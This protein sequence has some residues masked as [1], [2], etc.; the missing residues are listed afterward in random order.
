[1][2]AYGNVQCILRA[3]REI[4]SRVV[5]RLFAEKERMERREVCE[6]CEA[7]GFQ[8]MSKRNS[9][10]QCARDDEG[11]GREAE[12][13]EHVPLPCNFPQVSAPVPPPSLPEPWVPL[14][15]CQ[16][17][18]AIFFEIPTLTVGPNAPFSMFDSQANSPD[19]NLRNPLPWCEINFWRT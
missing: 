1:M 16:A 14:P 7:P 9:V 17:L 5:V 10:H 18:S 19:H 12:E 15:R 11:R 8:R 2:D 3:H 6:M 4:R 13:P